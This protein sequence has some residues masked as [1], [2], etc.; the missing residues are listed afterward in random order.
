[1]KFSK[2]RDWLLRMAKAEDEC[3]SIGVGGLYITLFNQTPHWF[4]QCPNCM[5]RL[6]D[7]KELYS[8]SQMT[9]RVCDHVY[10]DSPTGER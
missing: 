9:C 1:M 7:E 6:V 10:T 4:S 8:C 2:D 5:S 3:L